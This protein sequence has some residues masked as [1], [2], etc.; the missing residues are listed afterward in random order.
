MFSLIW[1]F[2]PGP[3]IIRVLA[4]LIMLAVLV[5]ALIYYIYPA[6]QTLIPPPLTTVEEGGAVG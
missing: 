3:K 5:W 1:R 6:I 4:M 2:F